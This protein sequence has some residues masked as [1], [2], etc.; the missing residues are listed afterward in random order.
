MQTASARDV[1]GIEYSEL[2][3]ELFL[4][5]SP[6]DIQENIV[7]ILGENVLR[8]VIMAVLDEMTEEECL[9]AFGLFEGRQFD[10]LASFLRKRI[11]DINVLVTDT[12]K[13]ELRATVRQARPPTLL[14]EKKNPHARS[15]FAE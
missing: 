7:S 6:Q 9:H 11:P 10:E 14:L 15:I 3:R 1:F 5:G 13:E 2:V 12:A 4:D 8:R